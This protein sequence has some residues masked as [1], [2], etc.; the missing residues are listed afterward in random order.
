MI[1]FEL[2]Y[3]KYIIVHI[4][5]TAGTSI[6]KAIFDNFKSYTNLTKSKKETVYR[7]TNSVDSHAPISFIK[8]RLID[9]SIYFIV[10]V[11][12][13]WARMF[14]LFQHTLMRS[15][16]NKSNLLLSNLNL[17]TRSRYSTNFEESALNEINKI[18]IKN[19]KECFEFWLFFIG[20]NKDILPLGNPNFNVLPQEWWFLENKLLS[21]NIIFFQYEKLFELENYL[22]VSIKKENKSSFDSNSFYNKIYN[23]KTKDYVFNLDSWVIKKFNYSF[24]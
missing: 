15:V 9:H 19:I 12:N 3:K 16:T 2:N 4:P 1:Y 11:R 17:D 10:I 5:K 20:R 23:N 14:S 13:P 8:T 6:K 22:E 18:G 21:K 7:Y 24:D